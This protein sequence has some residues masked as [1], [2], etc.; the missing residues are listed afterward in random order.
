VLSFC[1]LYISEVKGEDWVF[2]ARYG[3][4]F[5][6]D[7]KSINNPYEN[8]EEV[9]G[10]WQKIVYDNESIDRIVAHLGP[11]Y[12][13]L[14]ESISLIEID[15]S[16]KYAQT[17]AITYY[18]VSGKIIETKNITKEDWKKITPESPSVD[19]LYK[20]VCFPSVK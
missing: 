10:T 3:D 14:K 6:Y 15:C 2:Y 8:V 5:F 12:A 18:D 11:K 4:S 16:K 13:D 9:I 19:K 20:A 17:K 7:R 1:V